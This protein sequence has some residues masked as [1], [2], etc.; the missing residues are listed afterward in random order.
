MDAGGRP[1]FRSSSSP[2]RRARGPV[3]RPVVDLALARIA[4]VAFQL[5]HLVRA[6]HLL[7]PD[8]AQLLG[9]HRATVAVGALALVGLATNTSTLLFLAGNLFLQASLGSPGGLLT[10]GLAV[11]ALSP[12]GRVL[13][14][15]SLLRRTWLRLRGRPSRHPDGLLQESDF[16]AWPLRVL[17][18]WCALAYA[19]AAVTCSP[20]WA[21]ACSRGSRSCS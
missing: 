21:R 17:Q 10:V 19:A 7:G 2:P 16:A 8:A 13:S 15:D 9:V 5:L 12:S 3:S 11:L 4:I 14:L 6:E 18:W 1:M 20:R